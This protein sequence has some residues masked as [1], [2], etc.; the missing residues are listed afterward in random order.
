MIIIYRKTIDKY[1]KLCYT[2]IT[3]KHW[4]NKKC[5]LTGG[6]CYERGTDR[7]IQG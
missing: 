2:L 5:I 7:K 1:G 3:V 6:K 4:K